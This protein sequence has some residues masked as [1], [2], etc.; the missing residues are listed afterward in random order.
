MRRK[1]LAFCL[2]ALAGG[3][4]VAPAVAQEAPFPVFESDFIPPAEYQARREKLKQQLGPGSMAVFYTNSVKMRNNDVDFQFRA[5]S[6]FYYL[7]GFDEPDA[8]LMVVPDGFDLNG[9]KVTEVLFTN[10]SDT[11]SLTWLGY[12]MGPNNAVRM[13]G[14]EAALPNRDF[15]QTLKLAAASFNG[16][17]KRL[18]NGWIPS[19]A[20][21]GLARMV[22]SFQEW[23]QGSGF[24]AGANT[25]QMV[26]MMR[27]I[28]SPA[29]IALIK[30]ATDISVLGHLEAMRSIEPGMREYEIGWLVQYVFGRHGCEYTGYPPICGAGPNSTILHYNTNRKRM[31]SGEIM[32]MDT[33]G[34]YHGYTADVT[35]S[36]PVN[37]KFTPEQLAIY[38]VVQKAQEIG[39]QMCR[40]GTTM[41]QIESKIRESMAN[42][43]IALGMISSAND[44]RRYYMHGF[45]HGLGLDVHDPQPGTLAPGAVLTVEPGIYIKEGSPCDKKWWNIGV[46]I[47]DDIVVTSGDP[48]N[49]SAAAPRD[50]AQIEKLM[51]EKGI[52]NVPVRGPGG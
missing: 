7:T 36:F 16:N 21:G 24:D 45:G 49:L 6:N 22:R 46:R 14:V 11:M 23:K 12:R 1:I 25:T 48:I 32:C 26:R 38:K 51:K 43:L 50:P 2:L 27:E 40:P 3:S 34:E 5:D 42:D 20:N 19:D 39:I 15:D 37:G 29:E 31:E 17:G 10:V 18:A 33:A 44:L 47:E 52:G 4:V 8:A 9:K 30:K 28:K 41:G 13:L 35:R